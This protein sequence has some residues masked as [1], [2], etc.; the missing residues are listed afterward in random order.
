VPALHDGPASPLFRPLPFA[1]NADLSRLAGDTAQGVALGMSPQMAAAAAKAPAGDVTAWGIPF[2]VGSA[3]VVAREPLSVEVPPSRARWLVFMHTSDI[4]P[5]P[6]GD[7]GIFPAS[8]G[9]GQL[10]EVAASYVILYEDGSEARA[11]LRRRYELG[12]FSASGGR[13]VLPQSRTISR[14]RC[15]LI[16]SSRSQTRSNGASAPCA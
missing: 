9:A 7:R 14:T 8:R 1:G 13:T 12:R 16:S 15:P 6:T 11:S 5:L 2:Q 3:A 10:G 4:R